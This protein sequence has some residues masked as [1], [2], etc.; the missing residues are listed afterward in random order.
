M[1]SLANVVASAISTVLK[2]HGFRKKRG[3]FVHEN[4]DTILWVEVQKS[5]DYKCSDSK[6]KFTVNLGAFLPKLARALGDPIRDIDIWNGHWN[7]RLGQL[8]PLADDRWWVVSD[9]DRAAVVAAE[10]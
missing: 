7:L 5:R 10:V 4:E 3:R 6:Y 2:P 8:M 9:P 1:H